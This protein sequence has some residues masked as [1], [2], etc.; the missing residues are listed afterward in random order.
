MAYK[1]PAKLRLSGKYDNGAKWA[2]DR[3]NTACECPFPAFVG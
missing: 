3:T 1:K 2:G